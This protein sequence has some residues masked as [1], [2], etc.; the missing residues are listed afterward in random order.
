MGTFLAIVGFLGFIVFAIMALVSAFR[1]TGKAKKRFLYA[2]GCFVLL[3]IGVSISP[4][5]ESAST[6]VKT[7]NK[8]DSAKQKAGD[9]AKK[10]EEA[11]KR[12][13][14]SAKKKAE[15]EA[16]AKKKTEEDAKLKAEQETPQYKLNKSVTKALGEKSNRDGQKITTLTIDSSGNIVLKFKGDDNLTSN[17]IVT[18]VQMDLSDALKA[19]K[20]S[21]VNYKS[22]DLV[23]TFAMQDKFGNSKED[24]VVHL[25]FNK[26]TVDK[27]NFE[28]FDRK[29]IYSVA[30]VVQ[31]VHPEFVSK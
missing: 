13:E 7:E 21:E 14:E 22:V 18:G 29:N 1:K 20:E 2:L 8:G 30:D 16:A 19:I 25:I 12:A 15:A 23:A 5:A 31:F 10:K 24:E 11:Q 26:S 9:E 17:M 3:I 4:D 28:N 27:I 6:K